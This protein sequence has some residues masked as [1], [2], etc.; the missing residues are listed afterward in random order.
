MQMV[1]DRHAVHKRGV[2]PRNSGGSTALAAGTTAVIGTVP[3][4][5]TSNAIRS[6][7]THARK[8]AQSRAER[9]VSVR[10]RATS[11]I[12]PPE[13]H[14]SSQAASSRAESYETPA[15]PLSYTA[16]GST[17]GGK[18][19]GRFYR[20]GCQPA[21]KRARPFHWRRARDGAG[22]TVA[23]GTGSRAPPRGASRSGTRRACHSDDAWGSARGSSNGCALSVTSAPTTEPT[24]SASA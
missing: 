1:T 17:M 9:C 12:K 13:K 22:S 3:C 20:T 14:W 4:P 15:L 18:R 10:P 8:H 5:A 19:G 2:T 24:W 6:G 23:V 7:P 21:R 16:V 11:E